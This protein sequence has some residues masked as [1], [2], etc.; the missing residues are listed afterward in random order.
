MPLTWQSRDESVTIARPRERAIGTGRAPRGPCDLLSGR[1][2]KY[3][4]S[5]KES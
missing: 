3:A 5:L 4:A 2:P 1:L